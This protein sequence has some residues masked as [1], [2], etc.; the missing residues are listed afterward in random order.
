MNSQQ[1]DLWEAEAEEVRRM[2]W[3]GQSP[4]ALTV[5]RIALFLKRERQENDCFFVD[6]AQIDFWPAKGGPPRYGGAP[7]LLPLPRRKHH[8]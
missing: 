2:P 3:G 4:R 8:G 1:L 7:S 5:A 6:P